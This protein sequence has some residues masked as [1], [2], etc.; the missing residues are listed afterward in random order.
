MREVRTFGHRGAHARLVKIEPARTRR[1]GA[2]GIYGDHFEIET[3]TERQQRVV[4]THCDMLAARLRTDAETL[5]DPVA[6]QAK[7]LRNDD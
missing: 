2:V 4:C 1:L 5:L 7:V 3:L 6:A